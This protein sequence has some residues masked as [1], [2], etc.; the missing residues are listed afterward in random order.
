MPTATLPAGLTT[1][2]LA[3]SDLRDVTSV[4]AAQELCDLGVVEIE[5]A[6]LASDWQRP[7]FVLSESSVGV[8]ELDRLVAYAEL[9]HLGRCDTA[10]H[11]DK[12][13]RGIGTWLA[14][15]LV[16]L[17][18]SRGV[19]TIGMPVPSGSPG[20]RLLQHHGFRVRWTSWILELPADHGIAPRALPAG[21][22]LRE[23]QDEEQREVHDTIEDAFG[24]WS[25]R[26]REPFTDFAATVLRRP[27]AAPWHLRVALDPAGAV[28]G[29]AVI[30]VDAADD[31]DGGRAS[32]THLAVRR[33][34][35]RQGLAQALLADAT[36]A[37]R[38]HGV[39]S[40]GLS[41]DSRT[42]ALDLYLRVG[43]RVTSTWVNR[44]LDV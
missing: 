34:Q 20:D 37:A 21:Y 29:V 11:P 43:L 33:D 25:D 23:A 13:G 30:A 17:A 31:P 44:A 2:P 19:A 28:A 7:G 10:V 42:G 36:T 22:A 4:A 35:R 3:T 14:W 38:Q 16:D 6:D 40:I 41:T 9:G 24:E 12:R 26:E 39:A 8:L 15:W 27:G 18:R 32:I 5:E 1:R